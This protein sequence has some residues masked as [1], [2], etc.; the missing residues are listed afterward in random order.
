MKKS[1]LESRG[2]AGHSEV[3]AGV[4]EMAQQVEALAAKSDKLSL[5]FGIHR[6]GGENQ[7]QKGVPMILTHALWHK[8]APHKCSLVWQR[9]LRG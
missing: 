9:W 7:L 1:D 5:S 3:H 4:A 2:K 6:I 8:I